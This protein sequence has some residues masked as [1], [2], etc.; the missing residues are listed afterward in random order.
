MDVS[1]YA[2]D[3]FTPE[4]IHDNYTSYGESRDVTPT[5]KRIS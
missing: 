3:D 4:E 5:N 1:N 2:M